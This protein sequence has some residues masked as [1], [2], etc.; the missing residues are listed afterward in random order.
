LRNI[1]E[2][3]AADELQKAATLL[4]SVASTYADTEAGRLAREALNGLPL[5]APKKVVEDKK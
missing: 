3:K 1:R 5:P 4:R 2:H